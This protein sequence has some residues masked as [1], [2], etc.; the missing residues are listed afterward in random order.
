MEMICSFFNAFCYF[1]VAWTE[2]TLLKGIILI[3]PRKEGRLDMGN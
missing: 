1:L 2:P 3:I